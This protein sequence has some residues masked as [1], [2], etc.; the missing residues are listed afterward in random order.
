MEIMRL[1]ETD[2]GHHGKPDFRFCGL[3][4]AAAFGEAWDDEISGEDDDFWN[5]SVIA[6]ND[7]CAS[8][9]SGDGCACSLISMRHQE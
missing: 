9:K 5:L 8:L 1:K 2:P 7:R 3:G 6:T 4:S